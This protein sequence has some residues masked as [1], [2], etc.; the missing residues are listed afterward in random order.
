MIRFNPDKGDFEEV[1]D[2]PVVPDEGTPSEESSGGSPKNSGDMPWWK[3]ILI[4]LAEAIYIGIAIW[5]YFSF[6]KDEIGW[7]GAIF[8][9]FWW[10][11]TVPIHKIFF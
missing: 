5:I 2:I 3:L 9:S 10:I 1:S 11:I 4:Y 6:A 7:F 8:Y